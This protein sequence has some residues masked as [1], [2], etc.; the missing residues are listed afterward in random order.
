MKK[1]RGIL[2]ISL[3][4]IL[5]VSFLGCTGNETPVS[6]ENPATPEI[7]STPE[8]EIDYV[9]RE[10][11][12]ET[13]FQH[14][15]VQGRTTLQK[16][17]I[18]IDWTAASIEFICY[19]EGNV[20]FG[21]SAT[22][23]PVGGSNKQYLNV[24]V[25]GE[26]VGKTRGD[27]AVTQSTKKIT[28]K[29]LSKGR[30]V[31]KIERQNES[32]RGNLYINKVT[33]TGEIIDKPEDNKYFIEFIGDSI[34]TAYGNLYQNLADDKKVT[35][36][37]PSFDEYQDGTRSYACLTAKAL[38]VDYSI[39][40]QQGLGCNA[41]YYPHTM[42]DVYEKI[43]YQTN[44]KDDW[45]F[46]RKADIVVIAM[47]TNDNTFITNGTTTHEKVEKSFEEL[48]DMV[49]A[50]NPNAKI[51]WLV[52]MFYD[53]VTSDVQTAVSAK[54]GEASNI[55]IKEIKMDR[56]GGNGHPSL[57]SHEATAEILTEYLKTLLK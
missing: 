26:N 12:A 22:V 9:E 5:A 55:Y 28:I 18:A 56:N 48:I 27:Y 54:G 32:E 11:D 30:H 14:V 16:K 24:Y 6:S 40:A 47:G 23:T 36:K 35:T 15:K 17:G 37:E 4:V 43:C 31:I 25:D 20:E 44:R 49:R 39:V 51:V 57:A 2:L 38:G 50:N 53:G 8:P 19:C 41:G 52:G 29:D 7:T 21:I 42:N 1:F 33:L 3:C 45:S 10:Y 13:L 46:E 34:T